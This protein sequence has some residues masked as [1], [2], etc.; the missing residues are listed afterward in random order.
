MKQRFRRQSVT[1]RELGDSDIFVPK[2][3]RSMSLG[4]CIH[5]IRN[6]PGDQ[7]DDDEWYGRAHWRSR[8]RLPRQSA[9]AYPSGSFRKKQLF[10]DEEL[11]AL[12]PTNKRQ[13]KA[14]HT[15]S[16]SEGKAFGDNRYFS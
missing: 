10:A 2:G 1:R 7:D 6:D 4:A 11:P 14:P 5:C 3:G 8:R 15:N 9:L 12:V 13:R 16:I